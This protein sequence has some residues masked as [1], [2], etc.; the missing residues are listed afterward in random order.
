MSVLSEGILYGTYYIVHF[1]Y[2][3]YCLYLL[4]IHHCNTESSAEDSHNQIRARISDAC[5]RIY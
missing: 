5:V 4:G 1:L 3:T 2:G